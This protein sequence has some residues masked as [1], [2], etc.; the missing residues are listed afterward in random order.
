MIFPPQAEVSGIPPGI[1][2]R[3]F[4]E[5]PKTII[6]N[7]CQSETFLPNKPRVGVHFRQQKIHNRAC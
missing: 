2:P 6:Q 4:E 5:P 3:R 1:N 7:L